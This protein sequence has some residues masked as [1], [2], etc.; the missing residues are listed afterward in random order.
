MW[1][2]RGVPS[3]LAVSNKLLYCY[4]VHQCKNEG[5]VPNCWPNKIETVSAPF[6]STGIC[7]EIR[8]GDVPGEFEVLGWDLVSQRKVH[9][10]LIMLSGWRTR[11]IRSNDGFQLR[12]PGRQRRVIWH[13]IPKRIGAL[14][15][16]R[17]DQGAAPI[18]SA[19]LRPR[20]RCSPDRATHG[21]RAA[22]RSGRR[23]GRPL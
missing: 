23:R 4:V 5:G 17:Q 13:G 11:L 10:A 19:P 22:F 6:R 8:S 12:Q 21:W 2:G 16:H 1:E 14:D 15:W 3:D 20:P 18:Q 9:D 7:S